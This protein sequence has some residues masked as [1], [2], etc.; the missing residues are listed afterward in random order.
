M[1]CEKCGK[2]INSDAMFCSGCGATTAKPTESP[3]DTVS[4]EETQETPTG[5]ISYPME[6]RTNN[7]AIK[8][9]AG[10][11]FF[12]AFAWYM[13]IEQVD[14][15]VSFLS[16]V[17]WVLA[18][19]AVLGVIIFALQLKMNVYIVD[20]PYCSQQTPYPFDE[21]GYECESCEKRMVMVDGVVKKVD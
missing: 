7:G 16:I 4:A 9:L 6:T 21:K 18:V 13:A 12:G 10:C 8:P 2:Q 19:S 1:F 17:F 15:G 14:D 3:N 5:E 20:C 11:V